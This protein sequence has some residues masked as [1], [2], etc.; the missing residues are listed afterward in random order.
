MIL[1][2]TATSSQ[3]IRMTQYPK[4]PMMLVHVHPP[5]PTAVIT[6]PSAKGG[7]TRLGNRRQSADS[8]RVAYQTASRSG[9]SVMHS[10][11]RT[12]TSNYPSKEADPVL[13]VGGKGNRV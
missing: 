11:P 1:T 5:F 3:A 7:S 10:C 6:P 4:T 13:Q 9:S 2:T 8:E 12:Q